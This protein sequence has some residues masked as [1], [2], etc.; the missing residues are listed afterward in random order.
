MSVSPADVLKSAVFNLDIKARQYHPAIRELAETAG[1]DSRVLDNEG[2]QRAVLLREDE[3]P[4][5]LGTGVSF[6]HARTSCVSDLILAVGRSKEGIPVAD[7]TR[8]HLLFLIGTPKTKIQE[9]LM[10]V[11]FLARN[12]KQKPIFEALIH[13][14][15]PEAFVKSFG[16]SG[17]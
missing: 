10:V 6:P 14:D 2:F 4:T 15:T 9:Y 3:S 17:K 8:I 13:A 12:V 11:G 7:D 16:V 1:G 5:A